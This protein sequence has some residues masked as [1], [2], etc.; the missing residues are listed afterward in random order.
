[1]WYG[2]VGVICFLFS[3]S[4]MFMAYF[5]NQVIQDPYLTASN[6]NFGYLNG[7]LLPQFTF[8]P[9][10]N[11]ALIF[12]DFVSVFNF[13]VGIM[14]GGVFGQMMAILPTGI[15]GPIDSAVTLLMTITFDSGICFLLLY[16]FSNRSI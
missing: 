6:A 5:L 1:M 13:L 4:F 7:T 14:T 16:I 9:G 15:G 3:F 11:S 10:F 8:S 2:K 12:G